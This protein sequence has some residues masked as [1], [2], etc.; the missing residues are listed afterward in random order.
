MQA[1]L[2][3]R[4]YIK[5]AIKIGLPILLQ[6]LLTALISFTDNFM[7]GRL[8]SASFDGV[9]FANELF[10]IIITVISGIS[11]TA[12]IATS[13]YFGAKDYRRVK[14]S[15]K[16]KI[17]ACTLITL[18]VTLL[19]VNMPSVFLRFYS[20]KTAIVE[21]GSKYLSLVA[22]AYIPMAISFAIASSLQE[23]AQ[24]KYTMYVEFISLIIKILFNYLFIF[25][26]H[27]GVKGAAFSTIIARLIELS[28]YLCLM[29]RFRAIIGINLKTLFKIDPLIRSQI[30]KRWPLSINELF[31]AIALTMQTAFYGNY[32]SSDVSDAVSL[33]YTINNF[34]FIL[35]PAV[36]GVVVVLV[37]NNLG[38]D[39]IKSAESNSQK[40]FTFILIISLFMSL[41]LYGLSWIVPDAFKI[42]AVGKVDARYMMQ[43]T[44]A[45][46]PFW[47]LTGVCF[48]SVRSGGLV[49]SVILM[50]SVYTWIIM[51]PIA[52]LFSYYHHQL[53]LNFIAIY[54]I[55]CSVDLIKLLLGAIVWKR[56]K[57]LQNITFET[58]IT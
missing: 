4:Q 20:N 49:L 47:C 44:S 28:I 17:I 53:G 10:F 26:F 55:V 31:W 1:F 21:E 19:L 58:M 51:L 13:Q 2:I 54:A 14:D 11:V 39:N 56:K 50:D 38:A 3:D 18:I 6:T 9:V 23:I 25:V 42:S 30:I 36:A 27:W 22:W 8:G 35:F 33:G 24:P 43:I 52:F 46:L 57:W 16:F 12:G 40:T 34:V 5:Q 45:I 7:V 37:G 29:Y 15:V 48:H 32:F 41:L